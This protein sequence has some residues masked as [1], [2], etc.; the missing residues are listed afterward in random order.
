MLNDSSTNSSSS[1]EQPDQHLVWKFSAALGYLTIIGNTLSCAG[2]VV[3]LVIYSL[4]PTLRN[5]PGRC[6]MGLS[7]SLLTAQLLYLVAASP[8]L[9]SQRVPCVVVSSSMHF[10]FLAYFFWM[11]V[12]AFDVWRT[13]RG[14]CRGVGGA[15]PR[16]ARRTFALYNAYVW[17]TAGAIVIAS[18]ALDAVESPVGPA[19]ARHFCWIGRRRGLIVLFAAPLLLVLI[20]NVSFFLMTVFAIRNATRAAKLATDSTTSN[21]S[22]TAS[23]HDRSQLVLFARLAVIMGLTWTFGFLAAMTE[24]RALWYAFVLFNSSQGAF[25]CLAFCCT[26]KVCRLL[27]DGVRRYRRGVSSGGDSTRQTQASS[28]RQLARETIPLKRADVRMS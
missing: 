7:S 5:L 2:L 11:N 20:A 18:L 25:V 19:Y 13:F 6:L 28:R 17:G 24:V 23:S 21:S 9:T 10:A 3:Q 8:S 16:A 22:S 4:L 14:T 1:R 12:V 27:G 15:R 26:A